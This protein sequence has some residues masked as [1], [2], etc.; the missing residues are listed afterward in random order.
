[1]YFTLLHSFALDCLEYLRAA[2]FK[3]NT[4]LSSTSDYHTKIEGILYG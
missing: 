2:I 1:M 4:W 3:H